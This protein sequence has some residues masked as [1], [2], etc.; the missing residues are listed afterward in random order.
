MR[1]TIVAYDTL[2]EV[3]QF[4]RIRRLIFTDSCLAMV[5][6]G[7]LFFS[8]FLAKQLTKLDYLDEIEL[9]LRH[10]IHHVLCATPGV[11]QPLEVGAAGT[12]MKTSCID[13]HQ[14]LATISQLSRELQGCIPGWAVNGA[15]ANNYRR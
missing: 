15:E 11:N 8:E 4:E 13:L 14:R 12:T 6:G 7:P 5:K 9:K 1:T 2:P 10:S 3:Q